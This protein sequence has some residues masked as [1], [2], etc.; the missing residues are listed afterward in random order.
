MRSV[1]DSI[2]AATE[3]F[4]E[5]RRMR[6]G[7]CFAGME[8]EDF[9]TPETDVLAHLAANASRHLESLSGRLSALF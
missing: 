7:H 6:N 8:V 2:W 4:G 9:Q 1:A 5:L 3:N